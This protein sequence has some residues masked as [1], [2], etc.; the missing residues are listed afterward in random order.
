MSTQLSTQFP[1]YRLQQPHNPAA[2]ANGQADFGEQ[3]QEAPVTEAK[4][5]DDTKP[6]TE[7]TN[8]FQDR[9]TP[10]YQVAANPIPSKWEFYWSELK[11]NMRPTMREGD[12][13]YREALRKDEHTRLKAFGMMMAT[14]VGLTIFR[15]LRR[16][17]SFLL[18]MALLGKPIM[19][20]T[21]AFPQ[22]AEAYEEVK[23][24][25]PTKGREKF[26]NAL[27]ESFYS[28]FKDFFKPVSYGVM[29]AYALELPFAFC[30][31]GS[32]VRHHIIR[33]IADL[34]HIK[35]DAK[36]FG[37]A[38][39][40]MKPAVHWGDRICNKIRQQVPVLD[41]VEDPKHY[42]PPTKGFTARAQRSA[43]QLQ[44]LTVDALRDKTS[45]MAS[46]NA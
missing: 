7:P 24:G 15:R 2:S 11:A 16:T 39:E 4:A 42:H 46:K 10:Y 45:L 22:M 27:G 14:G 40:K 31:E 9:F 29:M 35:R 37:W 34:L 3:P 30:N 12:E 36:P 8:P 13:Q 44:T 43:K 17:G 18:L 1:S 19:V 20:T 21:Q 33:G 28:I 26:K 41:W 6:K 23:R 25:N 38:Y 32:G 5:Q